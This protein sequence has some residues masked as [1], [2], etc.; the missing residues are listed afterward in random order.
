VGQIHINHNRGKTI[1][2]NGYASKKGIWKFEMSLQIVKQTHFYVLIKN[3]N[4]NFLGETR[5]SQQRLWR[6]LSCGYWLMFQNNC[7][8]KGQYSLLCF[9]YSYCFTLCPGTVNPSPNIHTT[10]STLGLLLYPEDGGNTFLW[11]ISKYLP[12]YTS[13]KI[14]IFNFTKS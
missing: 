12:Y 3:R 2:H 5:L 4:F 9:S 6:L 13:Q 10:S 11:I 14:V 7:P 8:L 1:N